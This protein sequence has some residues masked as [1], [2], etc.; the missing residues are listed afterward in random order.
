MLILPI[1]RHHQVLHN[2]S[3]SSSSV[4]WREARVWLAAGGRRRRRVGETL[5]DWD[6]LGEGAEW[7]KRRGVERRDRLRGDDLDTWCLGV[8]AREVKLE[9]VNERKEELK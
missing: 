9:V 2:A 4:V 3:N 1:F 8:V 7:E 6:R 5:G